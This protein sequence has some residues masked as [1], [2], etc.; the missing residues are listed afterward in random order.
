[1][2]LLPDESHFRGRLPWMTFTLIGINLAC[3]TVQVLGGERITYGYSLTPSKITSGKDVPSTRLVKTRVP[4][5]RSVGGRTQTTYAETWTTVP[6]HPGPVPIHLTLLTSMFL[7]G[8]WVHLLGNLWFLW[9][10]GSMV[11]KMLR[12]DLFLAY[13]V[14]CGLGAATT[15]LCVGPDSILPYLGASGAISG[16]MGAYLWLHPLGKLRLWFGLLFGVIEVPALIALPIWLLL[17]I[18]S[19]VAVITAGELQSGVAYWAHVGGFATGL[20]FILS[21][22]L[23]LKAR[24]RRRPEPP[25]L[26]QEATPLATAVYLGRSFPEVPRR[27]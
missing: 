17:Q 18:L 20:I 2:F 1:M 6:H 3:F 11:E 21:L 14:A 26:P 19:S 4:V 15:H 5:V 10:F 22:I 9:I 24:S 25:T 7:H 16:V 12:P 8:G 13:Y 27:V 23:G